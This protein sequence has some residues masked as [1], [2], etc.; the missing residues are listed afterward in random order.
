MGNAP[1]SS[2]KPHIETAKKTKVCQLCKLKLVALPEE[3]KDLTE[4]RNLDISENKI[5]IVPPW[6]NNLK[7]LRGLVISHNKI[8]SLPEIGELR[9]LETLVANDNVMTHLPATFAH[10]VSLKDVNLSSNRL[11]T[12]PVQLC[13][14]RSLNVI[15]LS[16]NRITELP[17]EIADLQAVELNLNQ[18]QVS[19]LPEGVAR[20]SR[21]KVLRLEE[22]CLQITAFSPR[23]M[24]DSQISLFAIEGNV[25]DMKAFHNLE[26]YEQ[27]MERFTATKKKMT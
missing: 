4:L 25:F 23:I 20:C 3:L 5:E 6:I 8:V 7:N 27:Y 15:D 14:L 2:P 19:N 22:N 21:L 16:G 13:K 24:K 11:R 9:K 26:G 1:N 17:E 18:N 12:F 10:L